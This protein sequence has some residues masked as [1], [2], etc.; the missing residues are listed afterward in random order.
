MNNRL[1]DGTLTDY[2]LEKREISRWTITIIFMIG[3][4]AGAILGVLMSWLGLFT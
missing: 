3:M 4:G 1:K 2:M